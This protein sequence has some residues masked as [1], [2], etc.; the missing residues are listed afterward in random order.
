MLLPNEFIPVDVENSCLLIC[1]PGFPLERETGVD[2]LFLH[3]GA[4][5]GG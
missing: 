4:L 3:V 2:F 1:T 5:E